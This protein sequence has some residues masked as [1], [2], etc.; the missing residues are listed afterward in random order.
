MN[1]ALDTETGCFHGSARGHS[2][3]PGA[4]EAAAFGHLADVIHMANLC[5]DI[6]DTLRNCPRLCRFYERIRTVYFPHEQPAAVYTSNHPNPLGDRPAEPQDW[7]QEL[8]S[9]DGDAPGHRQGGTSGTDATPTAKDSSNRSAL[10]PADPRPLVP[11][12]WRYG[13]SVPA[14]AERPVLPRRA[15]RDAIAEKAVRDRNNRTAIAAATCCFV[16]YLAYGIAALPELP[17]EFAR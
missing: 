9:D 2:V 12:R 16:A 13:T 8:L 4:P 6:R 5:E 3:D 7:F 10:R 14:A 11:G 1:A 17:P 15:T